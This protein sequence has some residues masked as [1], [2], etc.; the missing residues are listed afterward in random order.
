[1]CRRSLVSCVAGLPW[2]VG[3]STH[4]HG[5]HFLE[6]RCSMLQLL[7]AQAEWSREHRGVRCG[8]VMVHP[9]LGYHSTLLFELRGDVMVH[10]VLTPRAWVPLHAAV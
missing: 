2:T 8:D 9:V 7:R 1:M 5:F 10:P 4:S 6:G 3:L